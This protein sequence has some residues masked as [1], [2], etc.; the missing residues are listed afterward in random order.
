MIN[1]GVSVAPVRKIFVAVRIIRKSGNL[2]NTA[3][4]V[5]SMSVSARNSSLSSTWKDTGLPS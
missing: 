3:A 5:E 1:S 4:S 2:L